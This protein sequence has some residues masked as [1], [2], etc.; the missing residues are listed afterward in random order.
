MR[1][2]ATIATTLRQDWACLCEFHEYMDETYVRTEHPWYTNKVEFKKWIQIWVKG[3]C[4]EKEV[5]LPC[6]FPD[7]APCLECR[8]PIG[9]KVRSPLMA[10]DGL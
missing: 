3:M 8:F 10:S 2:T 5:E 6:A 7:I 4:Y 9:L 1:L